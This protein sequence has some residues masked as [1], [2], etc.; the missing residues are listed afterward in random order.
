MLRWPQVDFN[1]GVIDFDLAEEKRTK[2]MRGKCPI[3]RAVAASDARQGA[4]GETWAT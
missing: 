3:R 4:G 2:K 1:A